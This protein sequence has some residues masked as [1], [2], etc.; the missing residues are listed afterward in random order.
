MTDT[1]S[2]DKKVILVSERGEATGDL[3][4]C[5]YFLLVAQTDFFV[6]WLVGFYIICRLFHQF[7]TVCVCVIC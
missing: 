7:V 5:Q 1:V 2:F 3:Q 6:V 4:Y